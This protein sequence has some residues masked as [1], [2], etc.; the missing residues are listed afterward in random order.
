M[1][2][3]VRFQ[4]ESTPETGLAAALGVLSSPVRLAIL[5]QLRSPKTL[6]EVRVRPV[7]SDTTRLLA[8]QTVK[9]HLDKLLDIGV[10]LPRETEREYGATTEYVLNH[11]ML[12]ALSEEFRSLAKLRPTAAVGGETMLRSTTAPRTR[13]HG[14]ALVLVKGLE[15]GRTFP[16]DKGGPTWTIGRRRGLPIALDFD[17]FVSSENAAIV[18]TEDGLAVEDDPNSRNGTSVNFEPLPKGGRHLLEQGDL[19][20]VGRSLLMFRA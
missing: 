9:E 15:E 13:P 5:R 11:Q 1:F 10:V 16:L 6:K 2:D 14:P 8:R 12:F 17:P 3:R 7:G 19:I 20:G 18:R 4:E